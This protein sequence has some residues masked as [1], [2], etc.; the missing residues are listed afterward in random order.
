MPLMLC[1]GRGW[2]KAAAAPQETPPFIF[3]V[4]VLL[5]RCTSSRV[6]YVSEQGLGVAESVVWSPQ[7]FGGKS[8]Q[9]T[10]SVCRFAKCRVCRPQAPLTRSVC[11]SAGLTWPRP[12]REVARGM[13]P[14]GA[15]DFLA[16]AGGACSR[17][18][19]AGILGKAA[20]RK[21]EQARPCVL[22][23][24]TP[25]EEK[26]KPSKCHSPLIHPCTLQSGV[27]SRRGE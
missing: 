16:L 4:P 20:E 2:D 14:V 25:G 9:R 5:R 17:G 15:E 19:K 10:S 1:P 26:L 3:R 18:R 11:C 13:C 27:S 7:Q 12:S 8:G 6:S 24:A 23:S 22:V 21:G